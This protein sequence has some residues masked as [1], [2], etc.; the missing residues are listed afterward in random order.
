MVVVAVCARGHGRT[1]G[2]ASDGS[3]VMVGL[4]GVCVSFWAVCWTV[5]A[6]VWIVGSSCALSVVV[7]FF[8]FPV[9]SCGVHSRPSLTR[10]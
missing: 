4:G 5:S 2:G 10:R 7:F 6:G 8:F 1:L 3:L 9:Y